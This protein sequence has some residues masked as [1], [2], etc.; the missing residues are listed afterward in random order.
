METYFH[1][2]PHTSLHLTPS[3]Y[4]PSIYL[5]SSTSFHLPL[6]VSL[7]LS[8]SLCPSTSLALSPSVYIPLFTSLCLHP[9][10]YLPPSTSLSLPPSVYIPLFTSLH[11]PPSHIPP[12]SKSLRLPPPTGPPSVFPRVLWL[13]TGIQDRSTQLPDQVCIQEYIHRGPL[14]CPGGCQRKTRPGGDE[15]LDQSDG[16]PSPQGE[17]SSYHFSAGQI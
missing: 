5:P 6:S 15:H 17:Y 14:G 8:I 13:L 7:S 12:P 1:F 2:P 10:L 11:L 4:P 3:V 16:I 9:S